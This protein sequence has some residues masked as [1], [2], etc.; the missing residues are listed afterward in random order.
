V[1]R[2]AKREAEL[3]LYSIL[4]DAR[5]FAVVEL[6]GPSASAKS[7]TL[8]LRRVD[9]DWRILATTTRD[10]L[11]WCSVASRSVRRQLSLRC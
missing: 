5:S 4:D 6:S 3:F 11:N 7:L 2:V 1:R 10:T 8:A 9:D